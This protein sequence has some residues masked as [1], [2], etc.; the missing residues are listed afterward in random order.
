MPQAMRPEPCGNSRA[1]RRILDLPPDGSIHRIGPIIA[2]AQRTLGQVFDHL[3][4]P[5]GNDHV[6]VF[7]ALVVLQ[8]KLRAPVPRR[9]PGKPQNTRTT[10]ILAVDGK[11]LFD[12]QAATRI[13]HT[14]I[15]DAS[16]AYV[17][18]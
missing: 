5:S 10:E 4:Q 15:P 14:T 13:S 8:R 3:S 2:R 9:L 1:F 7:T 16:A 12:P 11:G 17:I 18:C 6:A